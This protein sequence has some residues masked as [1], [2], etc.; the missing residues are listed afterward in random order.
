MDRRTANHRAGLQFIGQVVVEHRNGLLELLRKQGWKLEPGIGARTLTGVVLE[1]LEKGGEDFQRELVG[2][3]AGESNF[4]GE[5]PQVNVGADPVSAVAGA[6]GSIAELVRSVSNRK[7]LR[8]EAQAATLQTLL[9]PAVPSSGVV[10]PPVAPRRKRPIWPW[11]L[12]G[13]ITLAGGLLALY[14]FTQTH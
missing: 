12:G 11:S 14:H 5:A 13:G 8:R 2:L 6:V 3:L 9:Q 7:Q 1:S 4:T 10:Y